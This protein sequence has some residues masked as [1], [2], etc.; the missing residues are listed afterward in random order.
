MAISAQVFALVCWLL[1]LWSI[2]IVA[3]DG[4]PLEHVLV[5]SKGFAN[6]AFRSRAGEVYLIRFNDFYFSWDN[7]R[8]DNITTDPIHSQLEQRQGDAPI[9]FSDPRVFELPETQRIF[10]GFFSQENTIAL[11][12]KRN[13]TERWKFA[14][15]S[16]VLAE[17][18]IAGFA[19]SA[20]V[21]HVLYRKL[22]TSLEE[23]RFDTKTYS[24]LPS[25]TLDVPGKLTTDFHVCKLGHG[26]ALV[27]QASGRL[28]YMTHSDSAGWSKLEQVP[29]T[30]L[31]RGSPF[32]F[33]GQMGKLKVLVTTKEGTILVLSRREGNGSG[34]R[35]FE[36][37]TLQ[38]AS[39]TAGIAK[40][41]AMGYR[42]VNG[43]EHVAYRG[44][45]GE[46]F[47]A[48]YHSNNTWGET[49]DLSSLGCRCFRR[50][51]HDPFGY[52][53]GAGSHHVSYRAGIDLDMFW[54]GPNT[55]S[56]K[57]AAQ[58]DALFDHG[59]GNRF[60]VG[61]FNVQRFAAVPKAAV[62]SNQKCPLESYNA[63]DGCNCGCFDALGGDPDCRDPTVEKIV[64]VTKGGSKYQGVRH[65]CDIVTNRCIP[66]DSA[67]NCSEINRHMGNTSTICGECLDYYSGKP[68]PGLGKCTYRQ[69]IGLRP[70]PSEQNPLT[71]V[72]VKRVP[73]VTFGDLDND[74][75]LDFFLGT[76]AETVEFYENVGSATSPMFKHRGN[77]YFEVHGQGAHPFH[78][79]RYF[80]GYSPF[81]TLV[82][83]NGDGLLDV[84]VATLRARDMPVLFN[85]GNASIP[86]FRKDDNVFPKVVGT[87]FRIT[88]ADWDSD[89]DFDAV[90]STRYNG[91]IS[92]ENRGN[93]THP[94]FQR[95]LPLSD[96]LRNVRTT[97]RMTAQLYDFDK[98]GLVDLL[99]SEKI[100]GDFRRVWFWRN[101]GR[102]RSPSF[103]LAHESLG[104]LYN[105]DIIADSADS[106][107][108]ANLHGK[109]DELI[110]SDAQGGL[111]LLT[112]SPPMV[113]QLALV[114]G[115]ASPFDGISTFYFRSAPTLVDIDGDGDQD[116]ILGDEN[117][118]TSF[119]RNEGHPGK[120]VFV[121]VDGPE[122]PFHGVIPS[123]V[124]E[125]ALACVDVD[126]DGDLDCFLSTEYDLLQSLFDGEIPLFKNIGNRTHPQFSRASPAENPLAR[127]TL[128]TSFGGSRYRMHF[129]DLN[130]DGRKDLIIGGADNGQSVALGGE[131]VRFLRND[132]SG[133]TELLGDEN[134][135]GHISDLGTYA[136]FAC[137]DWDFDGDIDC[138]VVSWQ[139][140]SFFL[141]N[142][143]NA[144]VPKF[145][146][147][148]NG[149]LSDFKNA[150]SAENLAI[151][152]IDDDGMMDV[153]AGSHSGSIVYFRNTGLDCYSDCLG[154]GFCG[155]I[156]VSEVPNDSPVLA[157]VASFQGLQTHGEAVGKCWC[158]SEFSGSS[159]EMCSERFYGFDCAQTCP[160][161]SVNRAMVVYP[162]A[163][164]LEH[165]EC[166][167][168]FR[169]VN[170]SDGQGFDCICPPGHEFFEELGVCQ[171][172][173]AGRFH[174]LFDLTPC[175]SCSSLFG[176]RSTTV[177]STATD[178]DE[179]VC[180]STFKMYNGRC[181]C[182]DN[183][184]GP[185]NGTVCSECPDSLP[186]TLEPN[187]QTEDECLAAS[188]SFQLEEK[189][190][191]SCN[192]S[193][194]K[195][196]V[197]CS[198]KGITLE[199]LP[200]LSGYW[201]LAPTSTQILLCTPNTRC[202]PGQ[203]KSHPGDGWWSDI[204]CTRGHTG[205]QC[206][207]C[208]N[209]F[210]RSQSGCV[211]CTPERTTGAWA[212]S[213]FWIVLT[214][215]IVLLPSGWV[216]C[217]ARKS[218]ARQKKQKQKKDKASRLES[219]CGSCKNTYAHWKVRASLLIGFFQVYVQIVVITGLVSNG[220][221]ITFLQLFAEV[222]LS[223]LYVALDT[224][225]ALPVHFL[226]QLFTY[227]LLPLL[228]VFLMLVILL[229]KPTANVA[230][231][232]CYLTLLIFFLVYPGASSVV[233]QSFV[234][235][236]YFRSQGDTAPLRALAADLTI[237]ADSEQDKIATIYASIMVVVYPIGVVQ[238]FSWAIWFHAK[239]AKSRSQFKAK[240]AKSVAFLVESYTVPWFECYELI[241]KLILTSCYLLVYTASADVG[242][243]FY[244]VFSTLFLYGNRVISGYRNPVDFHFA[245]AS[246]L[247][248]WLLGVLP[249]IHTIDS[250]ASEILAVAAP[251]L[252]VLFFFGSG[253][254]PLTRCKLRRPTGPSTYNEGS[255]SSADPGDDEVDFDDVHL[256][257]SSK[258]HDEGPSDNTSYL[259]AG[260]EAKRHP[261]GLQQEFPPTDAQEAEE[262][263][264]YR[265]GDQVEHRHSHSKAKSIELR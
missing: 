183:R 160:P 219:F 31:L 99:I 3:V 43:S 110:V 196:R 36:E 133:F 255:G 195:D 109:G 264:P 121:K 171:Q 209:G 244:L 113:S 175:T 250:T 16:R 112:S 148:P 245:E 87:N 103:E 9:A 263:A 75:D 21:I 243:I 100:A 165:C 49:L 157:A 233:F 33:E 249:L 120:P 105:L 185:S 178:P 205:V 7:G 144:T 128:S 118:E 71:V 44:P 256:R 174:R 152:D 218:P 94:H 42:G 253:Y 180:E 83:L 97:S 32:C 6:L 159:C 138:I 207:D 162:E 101:V 151:A 206:E 64:C 232:V 122:N 20:Q 239:H 246:H 134:P 26:H 193:D 37:Q 251:V 55:A 50:P 153:I 65:Q 62:Q 66:T 141:L 10:V 210:T 191:A 8:Y 70:V 72:S 187:A 146:L 176:P 85:V 23:L 96:P 224:A 223:A 222:N 107:T 199:T 124:L 234:W 11:F 98:D 19:D 230:G 216:W 63:S 86:S 29:T 90:L 125:S 161:F 91:L 201:R 51:T 220:G 24:W 41:D 69:V 58:R 93:R 15:S 247:L 236:D 140:R 257:K 221:G 168:T 211:S 76:G 38:V 48:T 84:V 228:A 59:W 115:P 181:V 212:L 127:A 147:T 237:L 132:G 129:V 123:N 170:R 92:L 40:G 79:N 130:G 126:D 61:S 73:A 119:Y 35:M 156:P 4:L 149:P 117:G 45:E 80:M 2:S 197:D 167:P 60:S 25:R 164:T 235:N 172:C 188:G 89:G 12:E 252:E 189:Q 18:S 217:V 78:D 108:F 139:E 198:S 135:F 226:F 131:G 28:F 68:G 88:F 142:E 27:L 81:P 106:F 215:L 5:D 190:V 214:T 158:R 53:T 67:V 202:E 231:T 14:E 200:L 184:Y 260:K 74:G 265:P 177:T 52:V 102:E 137:F 54:K 163:S 262:A 13:E 186:F 95:Y 143:G 82:D 248:L 169:K 182:A 194:F 155:Q 57:R 77:D 192:G 17:G 154:R 259:D 111:V 34:E 150:L 114:L 204:Y 203:N 30:M 173:G 213:G 179:C 254:L 240:V 225:C 136:T 39:P 242:T 238:L 241:R 116:L 1:A 208:K 22:F 56:K 145:V 227:T 261:H 166:L 229:F 47:L 258:L 46:A 104:P